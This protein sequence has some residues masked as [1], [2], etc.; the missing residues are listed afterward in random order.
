MKCGPFTSK[1]LTTEIKEQQQM[2]EESLE[3]YKGWTV[4]SQPT[5]QE[6]KYLKPRWRAQTCRKKKEVDH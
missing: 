6:T 4:F 2:E 1:E 3:N 5:N